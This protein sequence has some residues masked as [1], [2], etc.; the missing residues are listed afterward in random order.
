MI[1]T[2]ANT[3]AEELVDL[4]KTHI[5]RWRKNPVDFVVETHNVP[6]LEVTDGQ[7]ELLE[8]Y[9]KYKYTAKKS[10][11]GVGKT[12]CLSWI[13][14]HFLICYF[15][16]RVVV[17]SMANRQLLSIFMPEFKLWTSRSILKDLF[18]VYD[19]TAG[20]AGFRKN[21][22]LDAVTSERSAKGSGTSLQGFHA[23]DMLIIIDEA[24]GVPDAVF[25]TLEGTVTGKNNRII[26]SGNPNFITGKFHRIFHFERDLWWCLTEN[27]EESPRVN[28]A[29]IKKIAKQYGKDSDVYRVRV[30]G[31]FPKGGDA[32]AIVPL[33]LAVAS[34]SNIDCDYDGIISIGMDIGIENDKTVFTI[35]K[36]GR[37]LKQIEEVNNPDLREPNLKFETYIKKRAIHLIKK[38]KAESIKPDK[39]GLGWGIAED[40]DDD[41]DKHGL[42][43]DY[44]PIIFGRRPVDRKRFRDNVAEMWFHVADLIREGKIRLP[45]DPDLITQLTTR[46]FFMTADGKLAVESKED[47]KKRTGLPSPD[48]ADSFCLSY[49][50][51]VRKAIVKT[52]EYNGG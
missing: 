44:I 18:E 4:F 40:I 11:Q 48:K 15:N 47:Y 33:D 46:R 39:T 7:V 32:S 28:K 2:E 50:E 20:I 3:T 51:G 17:T 19:Q 31:E 9:C 6:D 1:H 22:R 38:Y 35:R 21:W 12:A 42:S 14:E 49:Y 23:D 16:S 29:N 25:E 8:S 24:S 34:Q 52:I 26:A 30:K 5:P 45:N 10:G 37:I 27:A 43:C 36:G 41:I 13:A